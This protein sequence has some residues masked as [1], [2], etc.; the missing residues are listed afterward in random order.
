MFWRAVA[1]DDPNSPEP[2]IFDRSQGP[3]SAGYIEGVSFSGN[4]RNNLFL[5]EAAGRFEDVSG[6]SGM[7]HPAD[8][9]AMGIL[10]YDRDGYIDLAVVNANAPSFQLFRNRIG[11]LGPNREMLALRFV[12]SH[13]GGDPDPTRSNRDGYGARVELTMGD[14]RIVREHRAGEGFSSQNSR[15]LLVGLGEDPGA[16]GLQVRWPSGKLQEVAAADAGSLVTLY[17][18]PA[19]SPDGSGVVVEPYRR[20]GLAAKARQAS[21]RSLALKKLALSSYGSS[22]GAK[23]RMLTT[24]ATWCETCKGE[25][26]QIA[27]LR[28]A[29]DAKDVALLGVPVDEDDDPAK[30]ERYRDENEPAYEMLMPLPE[31]DRAAVQAAVM[32]ALRID[33][34]PATII[35]DGSGNVVYADAGVP[36]V[37]EL[38][39]LL[40]GS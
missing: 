40:A 28:D 13:R 19:E 2:S 21:P 34:L 7:D 18:D 16:L 4:E 8:G 15:T 22:N 35:V 36:S 14:S 6:L 17:E 3:H 30:L 26:P 20:P 31:T 32:E 9:R 23:L 5:S 1:R 27:L 39:S 37:S 12:G 25:L 11:D 33:A 24:M 38:R 29:F 10:D